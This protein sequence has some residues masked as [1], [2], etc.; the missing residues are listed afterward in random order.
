[1]H[2]ADTEE[3][4]GD[5][6]TQNRKNTPQIVHNAVLPDGGDDADADT[7][8]RGEDQRGQ[9]QFKGSGKPGGEQRRDRTAV[10][11]TVP[12]I[13]GEDITDPAEIAHDKGIV[14]PQAFPQKLDIIGV[15]GHVR[16]DHI[17][18][19]ID[20]RCLKTGKYDE[21]DQQQHGNHHQKLF[22]NKFQQSHS[23]PFLAV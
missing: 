4:L 19:G 8:H 16:G 1:M 15:G 22:S 2:D 9:R 5:G 14:E 13:A 18:N 20:A 10:H 7:Q 21:A 12:Q 23:T 17:V 6:L 3:E 11:D